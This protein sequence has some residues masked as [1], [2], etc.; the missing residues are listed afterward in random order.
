MKNER[1]AAHDKIQIDLIKLADGMR[2]LRLTEAQSGLSLERKLD[3]DRPV[4]RQ[5]QQLL[6][7]FEA[8]LAQAEL[9]AA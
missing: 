4:L 2:L 6:S 5:K 9:S 3:P 8:A 7:V 1:M